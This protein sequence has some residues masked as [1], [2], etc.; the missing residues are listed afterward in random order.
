M[1]NANRGIDERARREAG[2]AA[3]K[4]AEAMR[5]VRTLTLRVDALEASL[6]ALQA[7]VVRLLDLVGRQAC[8]A[9]RES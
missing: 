5:E 6:E 3:L 4:S 8:A 9:S 2:Q 7:S 1:S